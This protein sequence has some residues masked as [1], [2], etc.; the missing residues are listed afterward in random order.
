M[1]WYPNTTIVQ[2]RLMYRLLHFL[3]HF[4]PAALADVI[5]HFK[6]SKLNLKHI[7]AKVYLFI[8]QYR[9]FMENTWNF[10]E[11]NM[12]SVYSK[13]T[14]ADHEYFPTQITTHEVAIHY[15]LG[16]LKGTKKYVLK[17]T[18]EDAVEARKKY[19]TLKTVYYLMWGSIYSCI[20]YF[21]YHKMNELY[22]T[23]A[24]AWMIEK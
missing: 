1:I 24:K 14:A 23:A 3:Y 8:E 11:D 9:Y 12:Q 17:E 5:L 2:S 13:M 20:G 10:S 6:G 21:V 16:L 18:D 22:G 19:K 7:Y 4:I 15:S